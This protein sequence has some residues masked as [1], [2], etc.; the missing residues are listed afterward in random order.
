MAPLIRESDVRSAETV[1]GGV[2]RR[3]ADVGCTA[4][5]PTRQRIQC[6]ASAIIAAIKPNVINQQSVPIAKS[7]LRLILL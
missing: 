1:F 6:I 3:C 4:D 7:T 2:A 5:R